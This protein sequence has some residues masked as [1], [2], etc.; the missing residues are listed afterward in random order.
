MEAALASGRHAPA[1]FLVNH[2][3]RRPL[4]VTALLL[5][6]CPADP[7]PANPSFHPTRSQAVA[8]LTYDA[9]H[10]RPLRRPLV[11]ISGYLDPGILAPRLRDQFR[12]WTGDPRV[13]AVSPGLDGSFDDCRRDIVTA[14]DAAFPTADPD[15]T[16]EVDVL[17]LS[18]GGLAARAAALPPGP[19]LPSRRRLRIGRL[20][21]ISSPLRAAILADAA[22]GEVYDLQSAMRSGSWLYRLLND[23]PTSAEDVYPVYSYVRLGDGTVGAANAAVPGTVAWWVATPPLQL[24]HDAA[25][26]DARILADIA[27]RLRGEPALSRDPP[28]PLPDD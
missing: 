24:P 23:G 14:V 9:K 16:A 6:G 5:A 2:L 15:R 17:G 22:P 12:R 18:M 3:M 8:L 13:L 7:R 28:A 20:F 1:L 21:T 25:F 19:R 26:G 27:C 10:P 11:I 4:A